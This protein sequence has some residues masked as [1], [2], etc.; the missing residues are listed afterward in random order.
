[1]RCSRGRDA[2]TA[3]EPTPERI[4][5]SVDPKVAEI[6]TAWSWEPGIAFAMVLAIG[7]YVAGCR[8]LKRRQARQIAPWRAWCYGSGMLAMLLALF[9]PIAT[10]DG[11]LFSAHMVQHLLLVQVAVPLIWL[12]APLLPVLWAFPLSRRRA[13]GQLFVAGHPLHRAFHV[14]TTPLVAAALHLGALAVWHV[15]RFYDAAQGPTLVHQ[16][17]HTTFIGTA[18]LYWWPVVHPSGGRRRLGHGAAILYL[19]PLML[20]ENLIG[21][22]LTFAEWPLYATYR[23][24]P[25]LPGFSALTDQQLAGLI[26]WIPGG[27]LLLA[28]IFVLLIMEL[29]REERDASRLRPAAHP[30]LGRRGA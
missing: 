13:I 29:Q 23:D 28:P 9:S 18:L 16:L 2:K 14:L 26:M 19:F 4:G 6:L 11:V 25:G 21:A 27:L 8:R 7:F 1:M 24:G 22:L 5:V 3:R 12:G 20:L 17:E 10:L 30:D 15:P